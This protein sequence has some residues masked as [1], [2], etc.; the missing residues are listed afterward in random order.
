MAVAVIDIGSNS[1][2]YMGKSEKRLEITRLASGMSQT[3]RLSEP[4]MRHTASVVRSFVELA[5]EEGLPVFA[6][7][8]S[9][10]RDCSNR[11]EFLAL[12]HDAC[13]ITPDVLSGADEA[14]YAFLGATG[15]D[16]G[17]IDVGGGSSQIITALCELSF[18]MGC[19]RAKDAAPQAYKSFEAKRAAVYAICEGVYKFPKLS[20]MRWTAVGGSAHTL[21][22]LK[23]GLTRYECRRVDGSSL[24][25]TEIKSLS[26]E[27]F[28]MGDEAR[29]RLPLL[30][31]R[32]DV[33]LYGA[34]L[35]S[36]MMRGL[37]VEAVTVSYADGLEGYAMHIERELKRQSAGASAQGDALRRDT[38]EKELERV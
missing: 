14:R 7:A 9:A 21:A 4:A 37:G 36:Y 26:R 22:A 1:I 24:T 27:L 8:T 29:K 28:D 34:M 15:G 18:P 2:R 12:L 33:I 25:L 11:E 30:A 10:V 23:L 13:G 5:R 20:P 19:V 17:L 31:D 6:Y 38:A 3:G 35:L 32:H 16:G